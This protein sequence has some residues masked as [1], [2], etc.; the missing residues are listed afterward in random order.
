MLLLI[1]K[2]VG[3]RYWREAHHDTDPELPYPLDRYSEVVLLFYFPA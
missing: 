3:R 2:R 1:L